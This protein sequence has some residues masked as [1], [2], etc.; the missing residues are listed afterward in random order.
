MFSGRRVDVTHLRDST[1]REDD[2]AV[3]RWI[4][5]NNRWCYA[6]SFIPLALC[7]V[8]CSLSFLCYHLHLESHIDVYTEVIKDIRRTSTAYKTS[9]NPQ[10]SSSLVFNL[11]G[12]PQRLRGLRGSKDQG[13]NM[14]KFFGPKTIQIL[15]RNANLLLNAHKTTV[16]L[17]IETKMQQTGNHWTIVT[18]SKSVQ[19]SNRT[20]T[21]IT[22]NWLRRGY[23]NFFIPPKILLRKFTWPSIFAGQRQV[24]FLHTVTGSY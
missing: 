17:C 18:Q 9:Q 2:C 15:L 19:V 8:W 5:P 6:V 11:W 3:M 12:F 21:Y 23:S 20:D 10:S 4:F 7:Y 16:E 13:R 1:W 22:N 24:Q 14:T